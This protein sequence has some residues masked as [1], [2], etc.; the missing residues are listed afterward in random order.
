LIR[1]LLNETF[2]CESNGDESYSILDAVE[3]AKPMGYK[4]YHQAVDV[5]EFRIGDIIPGTKADGTVV[6]GNPIGDTVDGMYPLGN[7][8]NPI[9]GTPNDATGTPEP[10]ISLT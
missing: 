6:P 4:I 7:V 10:G 3:M 1:T 2:D 5:V 8:P 9:T